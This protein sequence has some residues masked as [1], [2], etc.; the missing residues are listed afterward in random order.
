MAAVGYLYIDL[1]LHLFKTRI[2]IISYIMRDI[3][4][5]VVS[6][7]ACQR[8]DF[9]LYW[10]WKFITMFTKTHQWTVSWDSL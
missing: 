1:N 6:Y 5:K 4:L 2:H 10:I 9:L 3:L 8:I 7:S